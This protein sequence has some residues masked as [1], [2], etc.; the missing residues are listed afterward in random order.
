MPRRR[1]VLVGNGM[2]GVR[3]LEEILT[4]APEAFDITVI[5]SEPHPNYNRILLSAVLAGD[6][7]LADIV[8]NDWD[9]YRRHHIQVYSGQTAVG[10]DPAHRVVTTNHGLQLAYDELIIATGSQPV[11]L[12]VPGIEKAG[13]VGFRDIQ[14]CETMIAAAGQYRRAVVI[15]GGL[16]GLE[17]ARGLLHLNMSVTVVH[18]FATLMERQLDA[19]AS[20][21]LQAALEGQGMRFLLERA[22][23][24]L[25]GDERVTGVRFTDGA[26]E[27]ADL[28]VV[29]AG[30]RPNLALAR[31]GGLCTGRG[32]LVDDH[33]Q[34]SA[35]HVYAIGEC[36]E[37]RGATYGL[38][39]PLFEQA[40]VL[41]RRL[42][43][44]DT[45]AYTGSAVH[46]KLKVS[47]VQVFS[48]GEWAEEPG[49]QA[50]R[51]HDEL[52][53]TYKK[54]LVRG[55]KLAGAVLFGDTGDSTRLL[56]MMREGTD[57]S[58]RACLRFLS[59]GAE[60]AAR[61]T[62]VAALAD[63]D[64]VCGCMGVTRGQIVR[65]IRE[66]GLTSVAQVAACTGATRSCGGCKPVVAQLLAQELGG[67]TGAAAGGEPICPCTPLSREQ[68][69]EAIRTQR[70]THSL[71]VMAVLNWNTPEGC[72]RCR[73]ALNYYLN[74][75]W[76]QEH[77]DEPESRLVNERLL[78]N[79]Q[80][81]GT[82]S[83]VPRMY[84]GVTTPD[85]LRRIADVAEAYHVPM[86]KVTGGQRIDLLGVAKEDLP[87]VWA[88]LG[89]P[90]GSAYG[91]AVRTVKTCVGKQFCRYGTQDSIALG[92]AMEKRFENLDTPAKIK[93][94]V[95][96]CPRNCAETGIKDF[97]VIGVEGGWE[98]HLGGNGGIH[99]RQ[100]ELLTRVGTA[101]EVLD[102][103]G[104]FLQYYREEARYGERTSVWIE[105]VGLDSVRRVVLD[106][107][108]RAGLLGRMEQALAA[109]PRDPW[110]KALRQ[111]GGR[112]VYAD[113]TPVQ[114]GG[115]D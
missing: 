60:P 105:R 62:P 32:I 44:D 8:L 41:A 78:A 95:S 73:P 39:A 53:G 67:A 114:M 61:E 23:A 24:E 54:V 92:I 72:S 40:A 5:G 109:R 45:A 56:Q 12:P 66:N 91:K 111:Q 26:V 13:V 3:C 47:G 22:T 104:A 90:S 84:G 93:M 71:E 63:G 14:D 108:H 86:I 97:G 18:L 57:V 106:P 6:A 115:N 80:A 103:C 82:F 113:L 30:I 10:L 107:E 50:I 34:T 27:P 1:L 21:M 83:V 29:A 2:A 55:G 11:M 68:V 94:A 75:I 87:A 70:L 64:T 20:A 43:G 99:V 98:I 42:S 102:I 81:N 28:V 31:A 65:A 85:Q 4:H 49:T 33:L 89:M 88:D 51:L 19:T 37:H 15:G 76:P 69:V 101:A 7:D 77:A 110:Q 112:S 59:G 35:P 17:A 9:W 38:V 25:T 16:L 46:T 74:M 58:D 100:T 52:A 36:A 48:A 79:I 96:A